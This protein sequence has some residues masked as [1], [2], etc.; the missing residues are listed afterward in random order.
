[1]KKGTLVK[2]LGYGDYKPL[3]STY[4]YGVRGDIVLIAHPDGLSSD[5]EK[6]KEHLLKHYNLAPKTT[7][8]FVEAKIEELVVLKNADGTEAT[9]ELQTTT[10]Q[11]QLPDAETFVDEVVSIQVPKSFL[12]NVKQYFV[13]QKDSMDPNAEIPGVPSFISKALKSFMSKN[14]KEVLELSD[15]MINSV[16]SAMQT[17]QQG[18]SENTVYAEPIANAKPIEPTVVID[19]AIAPIETAPEPIKPEPIQH[20]HV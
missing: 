7:K 4:V 20:I 17:I 1:M 11:V 2:F 14:Q 5:D 3:D 10:T 8:R 12:L 15:Y 13:A 9:T 19:N 6:V 16:D 18:E